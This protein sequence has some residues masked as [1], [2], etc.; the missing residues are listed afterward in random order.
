M[1]ETLF[2]ALLC[3]SGGFLALRGDGVF[4]SFEMSE[5][6]LALARLLSGVVSVATALRLL[7]VY[8]SSF[9]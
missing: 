1:A 7:A 6:D 8:I 5:K 2:T 9:S 3:I 4:R